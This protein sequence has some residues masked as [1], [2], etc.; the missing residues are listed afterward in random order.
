[1]TFAPAKIVV[2]NVELPSRRNRWGQ[3]ES[4]A[5]ATGTL[6]SQRVFAAP[7]AYLAPTG[8]R[9][10]ATGRASF[11]EVFMSFGLIHLL[12]VL[13]GC[14]FIVGWLYLLSWISLRMAVP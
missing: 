3:N 7:R 8:P 10:V 4:G 1:M 11:A 6:S 12:L 14:I 5:N 13:S 2:P 9:A